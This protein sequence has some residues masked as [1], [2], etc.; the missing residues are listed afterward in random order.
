MNLK[1]P[2]CASPS[3][4]DFVKHDYSIY[5]CNNCKHQ[6]ADIPQTPRHT[7]QTYGDDYF[8]EG[9]SGYLDYTSEADLLIAHGARYGDLLQ[10]YTQ[11]GTVFDV[12]SAAGFVLKGLTQRG[13]TGQGIEPNDTMASYA[14]QTMH[15]NVKTGVFEQFQTEEQFDL[16]TIIQV[17]AH[18]Y[19]V[20]KALEVTQSLVKLDGLLLI[21]TWDRESIPA[22]LLGSNWYEY[23][24]PSVV[25][26]F[27]IDGLTD[28][29]QQFGFEE[30]ARG[31]PAKLVYASHA[32]SLVKYKLETK[33]AGKVL[34]KMLDL[35]PNKLRIPYP[36]F[37]LFW[38]LYR[39]K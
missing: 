16:V 9:G 38:A 23:S 1:C 32:K 30:I 24:P 26:W 13:W 2:I 39:C 14:R 35:V 8:F 4:L 22:R 10:K 17:I 15:M 33:P 19:D 18:F 37:D 20:R 12:G 7:E 36:S 31:R 11:A 34:N 3:H 21:E 6:F 27:S 28:L 5:A 29:V 25:N